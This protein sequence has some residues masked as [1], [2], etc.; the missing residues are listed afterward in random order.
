M[1]S[2]ALLGRLEQR[3]GEAFLAALVKSS[4]DAITGTTPD[5]AIV[6]WNEAAERLYGYSAAEI[7]GR[8]T[9]VLVPPDRT[10]ELSDLL[11]RVRGG[12]TVRHTRTVRLRKDGTSVPVAITASPVVDA[13]GHMLGVSVIAHDRGESYGEVG[14][15]ERSDQ[16]RDEALSLLDTLQSTAPVGFIFVD[17]EFRYVCI[18]EMAAATNGHSPEEHLGRTVAEVVPNLWS[19]IEPVYR[20][21]LDGGEAI[22]NVE[23]TGDT[24]ASHGHIRTWLVSFYPVRARATI[25]GIGVV[26]VDIT[27]RREAERASDELIRGAVGAIAATAEARDPYTAGHQH[28][29][30]DIAVAIATELGLGSDEVEGIRIAAT[31]HDVGKV[32][33]PVEILVRPGKLRPCE[34]EMI[35]SHSRAGYEILAD[36]AFPQPVAKMVLQHHE[37]CD[38]SGYPDGLRGDKILLGAR[39]IAV[40]DTVEAMSSHRPYRAA[41]GLE[42]ALHEI[43][44]GR[45]TLF[46]PQVVDA[47]LHLVGEGLLVP[48]RNSRSTD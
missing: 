4:D 27:E 23:I 36:I 10:Q 14:R 3:T 38:G 39:V 15:G 22:R 11:V 28:R 35:R 29:V 6:L 13:D 19:Q 17:C 5:G 47:C 25:I 9:A 16:E 30:A 2:V 46:D 44:R 33:V 41:L 42:A 20:Q 12:E 43:R 32:S 1:N 24:E 45:G 7:L 18:N 26:S 40:A 34:W 37:R 8:D 21:V 48:E 31:I